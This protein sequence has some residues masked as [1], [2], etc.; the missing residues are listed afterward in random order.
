MTK[1]VC[2]RVVG[3]LGGLYTVLS[4][5]GTRY[6]CRA[7]GVLRRDENRLLVGDRVTLSLG[8][9]SSDTVVSSIS[10]R[11]NSL[12]RPPLANL[13]LLFLVAA[14][15]EPQPSLDLMD[16]MTA[17]M[18]ENQIETV[19]LVTKYDRSPEKAEALAALYRKAGFTVFCLSSYT[20]AGV[21][22]LREYVKD[23]LAGKTAAFAGASGVG[24]STLLNAL[25]P[26]LSLL[27]GE[28]SQKTERG[29]HTTRRTDL[30]PLYG[31]FLADTPGFSMLDFTRFDFFPLDHLAENFRDFSPYFGKC[32]YSDCTHTKEEE[33]AIRDAVHCGEIAESRFQSYLSLY[34]ELKA[35]NPYDK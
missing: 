13:D 1:E 19:L 34:T 25:F 33:C 20:G 32:R 29:R 15:T 30:F 31:G 18:A 9:R 21:D 7:K 10:P 6:E 23:A 11:K 24:K 14:A 4:E 16:K 3:S 35:K 28:V 8:E 22:A 5:E 12:L 27:T 26:S 17:I 2:G